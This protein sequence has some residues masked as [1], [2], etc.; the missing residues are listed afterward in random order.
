M[1]V[2]LILGKP[3]VPPGLPTAMPLV[4]PGRRLFTVVIVGPVKKL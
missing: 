4:V 2:I 3:A 1:L